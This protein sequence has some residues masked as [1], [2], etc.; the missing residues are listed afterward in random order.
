MFQEHDQG[1]RLLVVQTTTP[2]T[3]TLTVKLPLVSLAV[4]AIATVPLTVA[5]PLRPGAGEVMLTLGGVEELLTVCETTDEA[6]AESLLSP[7]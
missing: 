1:L 4:P 6:L 5:A 2:F 3:A 7:P